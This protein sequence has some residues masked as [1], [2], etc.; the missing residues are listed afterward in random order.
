MGNCDLR[1]QLLTKLLVV[2]KNEDFHFDFR[3]L[4]EMFLCSA[5][6]EMEN[7]GED[8]LNVFRP[9]YP[10]LQRATNEEKPVKR[11]AYSL[12]ALARGQWPRQPMTL[13]TI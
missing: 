10:F 9:M 1:F 12:N 7:T 3:L 4:L 13:L 2:T 6:R 8:S 11:S 5:L